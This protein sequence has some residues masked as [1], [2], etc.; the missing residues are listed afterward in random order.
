MAYKFRLLRAW[1]IHNTFLV[2]LLKPYKGD[3][4]IKLVTKEPPQVED[5]EEI[6]QLESII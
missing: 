5:Q 2:S 1:M 6:L 3:L 4:L